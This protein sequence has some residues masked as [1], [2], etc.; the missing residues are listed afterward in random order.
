MVQAEEV[1][2][3]REGMPWWQVGKKIGPSVISRNRSVGAACSACH[4]KPQM[5]PGGR[6]EK[7]NIIIRTQSAQ[8]EN[9]CYYSGEKEGWAWGGIQSSAGSQAKQRKVQKQRQCSACGK[10]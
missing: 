2:Y 7:E 4:E 6:Q 10:C 1:E 3:N 5:Q 9:H 8:V